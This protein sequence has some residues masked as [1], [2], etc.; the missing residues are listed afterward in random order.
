MGIIKNAGVKIGPL[1]TFDALFL[2]RRPFNVGYR[3]TS[4]DEILDYRD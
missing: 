1:M 2:T 3:C 4:P